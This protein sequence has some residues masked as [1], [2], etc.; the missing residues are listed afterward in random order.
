MKKKLLSLIVLVING[1]NI[2]SAQNTC[3]LLPADAL[4][5]E[6]VKNLLCYL[7]TNT[8]ISGQTVCLN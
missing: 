7:K 4:A 8:Y 3:T 2:I 6:Q 5:T 1:L